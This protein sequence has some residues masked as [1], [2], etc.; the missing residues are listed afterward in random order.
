MRRRTWLSGAAALVSTGAGGAWARPVGPRVLTLGHPF[1]AGS[2]PDRI[3][4]RLAERLAQRSGGALRVRVVGAAVLGDEREHLSLL[5]QAALD[6][7][8]AGDVVVGSLGDAYLVVNLP[9]LYR[10][11][12]HALQTYASPVGL[13]LRQQLDAAGLRVLS[14]HYVG[15]RML[16]ANRPIARPADLAGLRLRLPPDAAW[17]AVW[18]RLGAETVPIPFPDLADALRLGKVDAQENPPN[19]VRAGQLHAHQS[20]LMP[21]NHMP[22]RQFV[23]AS[24]ARW[25][26]WTAAQRELVAACADEASAWGSELARQEQERDARWLAEPGR[27]TWVPW[28]AD[29]L[30]PVLRDVARALGGPQGLRLFDQIQAL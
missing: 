12:D 8:V 15:T 20:H 27:L 4:Q 13:A 7:T 10:S 30:Q 23:F 1:P 17:T 24:A 11:V 2:M 6:L 5:R 28:Q 26:G 22:Q 18:R 9:F 21:S 14:W 3:A 25:A 19:F 29:G 16:T